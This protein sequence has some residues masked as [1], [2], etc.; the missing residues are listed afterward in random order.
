MSRIAGRLA[1]RGL[2]LPGT[3]TPVAAYVPAVL[4]GDQVW[5]SGQL[6]LEDGRL[7]VTGR[8]GLGT[9]LVDPDTAARLAEVCVLNALAAVRS[10]VPDL[11]RLVRVIRVTGYV[12]S[13]PSFTGQSV[14]LNGASTLLEYLLGEP[15][16]HARSAVGV[17]S[18]P[19]DAPV[20]LELLVAVR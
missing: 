13:D 14:V 7:R 3:P 12:A 1:D 6:P 20:E 15:G 10:V 11:D 4:H 8:V 2:T 16:Q 17:A 18:L 5:T 19:L 9:G